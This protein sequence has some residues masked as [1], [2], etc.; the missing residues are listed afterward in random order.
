MI[1]SMLLLALI[2]VII[3]SLAACSPPVRGPL[4]LVELDSGCM[5]ELC[6]GDKLQL[7]LGANPT[8]GYLWEMASKDV[9]VVKQAGEPQFEADSD[10]IGSGGKV[11]LRFEAV[12][13]GEELLQLVYHRP[14]E[15]DLAPVNTFEVHVLV[16]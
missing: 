4:K 16:K 6:I 11:T 2:A 14:F 15:T 12:A 8:T 13:A 7:V 9:T 5:V 1:R 10:A 3:L